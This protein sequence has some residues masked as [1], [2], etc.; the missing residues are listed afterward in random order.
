MIAYVSGTILAVRTES[1]VVQTAAGIGFEVIT[2]K[3]DGFYK[4]KEVSFLTWMQAR[5]DGM[6]LYGFQEES[7]YR[8][9]CSLIKI[10]GIGPKTAISMLTALPAEEMTAAI[11]SAD[12][13]VL[14]SL[15]GIG[16]KTASQMILDLKGKVVLPEQK[17]SSAPAKALNPV[18]ASTKEAL[19]ALGYKSQAL[20]ELEKEMNEK[21]GMK[22]DE[23]LRKSLQWLALKNGI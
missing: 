8:L 9:F 6:S 1:V 21:T 18:W 19:I 10:K 3:T 20:S 5:E 14:K 7:A 17:T 12:V 22:E 2:G 11:E 23:M 16:A 15:P 4:E 13:K